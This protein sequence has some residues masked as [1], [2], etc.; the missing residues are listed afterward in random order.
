MK[1]IPLLILLFSLNSIPALA[2]DIFNQNNLTAW[3]IVP[4]DKLKRGPDE[5]I[6]MLEKLNFKQYVYDWRSEHIPT[7]DQEIKLAKQHNIVMEGVWLWVN[8]QLDKA[9]QLSADNQKVIDIVAKNKLKTTFWL[10]FDNGF[11]EGLTHHERV[12]KGAAFLKYLHSI[13]TPLQCKIALYNH[14]GWFGEPENEIEIIKKAGLKGVGIVYSFHHGHHQINRFHSMLK[15]MLPY[16]V[17]INLDG[18]D[19]SKGQILPIGS[20]KSE[21]EMIQLIRESGYKGRIG[22]LGHRDD[23][24]VEVVLRG[25]LEGLR[26]IVK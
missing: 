9:G 8:S 2:Q 20:G 4:F 26:G 23:E 6:A 25:N 7:F 12:A 11:F 22:V 3:C 18:M 1:I 10:G 15:N 14:G 24:D 16:L 17:A 19:L 21:K 13:L 5:R